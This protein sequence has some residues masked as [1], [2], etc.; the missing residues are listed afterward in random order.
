MHTKASFLAASL[1]LSFSVMPACAT[2]VDGA[3]PARIHNV[4]GKS[5]G[6]FTIVNMTQHQVVGAQFGDT[7]MVSLPKPIA[8]GETGQLDFA[9]KAQPCGNTVVVVTFDDDT[10][11]EGSIDLCTVRKLTLHG[12]A[13]AQ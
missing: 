7:A 12:D 2:N 9:V 10:D 6:G 5:G 3:K 4:H 1:L 11:A 8:P 13:L